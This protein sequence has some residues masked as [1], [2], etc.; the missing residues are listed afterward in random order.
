MARD[1]SGNYTRIHNWV[2]D[3]AN[4]IKIRADRQDA[5][6]DSIATALSESVAR[7]GQTTITANLPMAGFRHTS[8][9]NAS[10]RNDYAAAGQ[11]QDSAFLWGGTAGGTA[12]ALT[13]SLTPVI[14]AYAAG[15]AF[16]FMSGPSPNTGAAT[17][18]INGVGTAAIESEGV[19]LVAGDITASALHQITHDGTAFQLSAAG[20]PVTLHG[21]Q[22]ITGVKTFSG[23][24]VFTADQVIQSTDGGA[25]L[26]PVLNLNR[27][28][29]SPFAGDLLGNHRYQGRDDGGGI[30]TYA[31]TF[32]KIVSAAAGAEAG[33]Y[34]ISTVDSGTPNQRI[35]VRLGLFMTGATGG[36]QGVDTINAGAG[37]Y[38]GDGTRI[39]HTVTSPLS[40]DSA[41]VLSLPSLAASSVG[42]GELKT[43]SGE[44]GSTGGTAS[45]LYLR[46]R[47]A[48][49]VFTRD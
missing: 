29:A 14:T 16:Q 39:P 10:A 24:N 11:A 48:R 13:I 35:A 33:E 27:L 43:A 9:G 18:D 7:D 34:G 2:T 36:D 42:Q 30:N 31:D 17:I 49:M 4:V 28:S 21:V 1:G 37:G 47:V 25:G 38:F 45:S 19:A 12:D 41:G 5:E 22:T 23:A 6:D 8:V 15:Q 44:V 46:C 26:G 32:A 40:L 20:V 3:A